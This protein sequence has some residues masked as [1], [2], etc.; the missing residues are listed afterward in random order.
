V[1]TRRLHCI[2]LSSLLNGRKRRH[3]LL[4]RLMVS[5]SVGGQPTS[6][7]T[8]WPASKTYD[9]RFDERVARDLPV[10]PLT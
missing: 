5:K 2:P 7:K 8:Q 4:P 3:S 1:L 9:Q 10:T 6:F